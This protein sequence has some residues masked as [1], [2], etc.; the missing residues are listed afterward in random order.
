MILERLFQIAAVV[1]AVVAVYFYWAGIQ[2]WM[3]V[4]AVLGCVAFFLS[5]RTQVKRRNDERDAAILAAQGA[6]SEFSENE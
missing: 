6:E 5:I 4:S 2:D 1:L 3:Y